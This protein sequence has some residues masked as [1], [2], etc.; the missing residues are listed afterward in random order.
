MNWIFLFKNIV[1]LMVC[2]YWTVEDFGAKMGC[3]VLYFLS[4]EKAVLDIN[5]VSS[6][7]VTIFI[8]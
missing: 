5:I 8:A 3:E 4:T 6:P 2:S 7:V 1:L